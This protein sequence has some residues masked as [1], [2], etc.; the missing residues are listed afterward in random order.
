[1]FQSVFNRQKAYFEKQET[2]PFQ[3]RVDALLKLKALIK[4]TESELLAAVQKDL[5]KSYFEAYTSEILP[6]MIEIDYALKRIKK[7][8]KP[9]KKSGTPIAFGTRYKIYPE[10]KG[11]V[12]IVSP[13]NYPIQLAFLP[14]VS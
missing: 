11:Q 4:G 14:L 10:P 12:L 6:I 13:W 3:K 2:K 7:W 1:M 8:M 9:V 5:N